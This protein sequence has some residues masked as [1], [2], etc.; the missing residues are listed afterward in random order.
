M[1]F[2]LGSVAHILLKRQYSAAEPDSASAHSAISTL[3]DST[4]IAHADTLAPDSFSTLSELQRQRKR[5]SPDTSAS[6]PKPRI[7]RVK[8]DINT[9]VDISASDSLVLVGR[10]NAYLYG[11]SE[12]KYGGQQIT[13]AEIDLDMATNTVYAVG[14]PDSTGEIAGNPVFEDNGSQ[15][16]AKTMR[17]NFETEKGII[18]DVITEQGEG[19]LTGG[20]TKKNADG[21]FFLQNGRYTTCDNH[22]NPHFYFQITKAKVKPQKDIV[23]G[24]GYMVLAGLP[25]PLALPF[26]Y[27]PFSENTLQE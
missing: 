23:T 7:N 25:L 1:G 2:N 22:D 16:Q 17:Y 12:V 24:P 13:A 27:F 3:N 4:Y 21:T 18:T 10:N 5:L 26:G 6:A 8:T 11:N 9:N 15:Y 19:Y 20:V 14:A